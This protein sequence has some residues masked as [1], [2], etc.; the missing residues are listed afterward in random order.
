M[1]NE[2]KLAN[3]TEVVIAPAAVHL[4]KALAK[5]RPDVAVAAQDVWSQGG[6]AFTGETSAEML[7][8]LGAKWTLTGEGGKGGRDGRRKGGGEGRST[9]SSPGIDGPAR[10]RGRLVFGDWRLLPTLN[11]QVTRNGGSKER[12]T[13]SWPKRRATP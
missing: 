4:H 6:G 13:R 5:V 1:L 9:F 10:L 12:A 8:D 2:S 11:C 3:T 7:K